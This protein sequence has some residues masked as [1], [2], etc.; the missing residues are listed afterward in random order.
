MAADLVVRGARIID[1]TGGPAFEGDVEV[2]DGVSPALDMTEVYDPKTDTYTSGA[3]R[4]SC[5]ASSA[6]AVSDS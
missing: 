6:N 1:G 3:N 5:R 2:T 4:L